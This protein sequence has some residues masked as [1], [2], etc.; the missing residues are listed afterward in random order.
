M[1]H[2][3]LTRF[4][5][6]VRPFWTPTVQPGEGAGRDSRFGGRPW[7]PQGSDWP[8]LNGEPLSLYAQ[9]DLGGVPG[10][11][12]GNG[13]LQVFLL[14]EDPPYETG[15]GFV[16]RIVPDGVDG[17]VADWPAALHE[18]HR[19]PA[20]QITG[21]DA[22]TEPPMPSEFTE[23]NL[24]KT[25]S[26][27]DDAWIEDVLEV[28]DGWEALNAL[29]QDHDKLGGW[30]LWVQLV[31]PFHICPDCQ[32]PMRL[33][34]QMGSH[35]AIA[36]SWGDSGNAYLFQCADHPARFRWEVQGH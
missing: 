5:S 36:T 33:L 17:A 29:V 30:P 28:D 25:L 9:I 32:E 12:M 3:Y 13:L 23:G 31:D 20:S 15:P 22:G 14:A 19:I 4:P 6:R 7:L 24:A 1:Q 16:A 21:W 8:A 2:D 27:E 35:Q 18:S 11:P 26:D 34:L 10:S